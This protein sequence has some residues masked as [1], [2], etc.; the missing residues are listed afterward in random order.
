MKKRISDYLKEGVEQII[1]DNVMAL[2]T[3]TIIA[4]IQYVEFGNIL[5]VSVS[6]LASAISLVGIY[7]IFM[8]MY[9]RPSRYKFHFYKMQCTFIYD[10]KKAI[11]KQKI[12]FRPNRFRV[13]K[14][15]TEKTWYTK[16]YR[17]ISLTEGVH[18]ELIRKEGNQ[19]QYYIV[20][21]K[22]IY[23]WQ[24]AE[25]EV[26]FEGDNSSHKL[27]EYYDYKANCPIDNLEIDI[28][29][30]SK[31]C[32]RNLKLM[33]YESNEDDAIVENVNFFEHYHWD[34][35]NRIIPGHHYMARWVWSEEEKKK[36]RN[37]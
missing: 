34:V 20:F 32:E 19:Q 9:T 36:I 10:G 3:G 33:V 16:K 37:R 28:I 27:E 13:T 30:P 22:P 2:V 21:D 6:V 4:S 18:I 8:V 25:V 15:Y 11:A 35:K 1:V 26:V 29:M 17:F 7:F 5:D 31:L 23:F 24:K 14:M 12:T